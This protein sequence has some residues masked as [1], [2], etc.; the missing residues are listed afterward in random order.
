MS[1]HPG[2]DSF[3]AEDR[4][5]LVTG[6][7][8]I[9]NQKW[10]RVGVIHVSVCDHHVTNLPLFVDGQ[11]PRNRPGVNRHLGV[12]KE[13][14]HPTLGAIPTKA[15]QNPKFHAPSITGTARLP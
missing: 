6:T 3:G 2:E 1:A 8:G 13:G 11:R 10:Q 4:N 5:R 12:N 15:S 7:K 14:G 9:F